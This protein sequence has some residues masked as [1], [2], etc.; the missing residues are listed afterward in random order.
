MTSLRSVLTADEVA[1]EFRITAETVYRWAR[2]GELKAL[3][4]PGRVVRFRR[5][6]IEAI[7]RGEKASA[8]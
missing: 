3:D 7:L 4:L 1:E 6:D 8:A 2:E 5:E